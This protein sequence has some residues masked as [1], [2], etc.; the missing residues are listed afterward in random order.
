LRLITVTE[1]SVNLIHETLI[2]T[3]GPDDEGKPLPYWPT[4]W[5][6]I[7]AP[8]QKYRA[9]YRDQ[10]RQQ[11]EEWSNRGGFGRWR[12]AASWK[13]LRQFAGLAQTT[14][15][16]RFFRWSGFFLLANALSIV[17]L[18]SALVA[19]FVWLSAYNLP[20][21]RYWAYVWPYWLGYPP[22]PELV[23]VPAGCFKMGRNPNV[24]D[25][26]ERPEVCVD[27]FRMGHYEVTFAE[28]DFFVLDRQHRYQGADRLAFPPDKERWG[29]DD[30]PVIN[31]RWTDAYAYTRWLTQRLDREGVECRLPTEQ[32]WEHAA[33]A[34]TGKEY[35]IPAPG[36][37]N[38]IS[39]KFLE[40]EAGFEPLANCEGCGGP[41]DAADRTSPVG[42]FAPNAS[43]LH[44]MHGNVWEWCLN[45][46]R[47]PDRTEPG[48]DAPRALR[49]G[50][51]DHDPEDARASNR[52]RYGPGSSVSYVGFRVMCSSPIAH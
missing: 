40:G 9:R 19:P 43:G 20:A 52:L 38:T 2:R 14:D 36:G 12:H 46:Y 51:W 7:D 45:E 42:S 11:S 26:D 6:Y 49:G 15:E 41:W 48:G 3:K 30:R 18:L 5:H 32:E 35:G 33:R 4:L 37:S 25:E 28:Y 50:S 23:D 21:N 39:A 44:D 8:K 1:G 10:L 34:G 13:E 31:V 29:R 16:R 22:L 24:E 27:A 17:L 47:N